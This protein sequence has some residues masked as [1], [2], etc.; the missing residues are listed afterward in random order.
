MKKLIAIAIIA[1][2]AMTASAQMMTSRTLLKRTNPA[3]W[4]VHAGMSINSLTGLDDDDKDNGYSLGSKA[5]FEVDFGFNKA[6]GRSGAYWG[7]ELGIGQRGGKVKYY[8]RYDDEEYESSISSWAV[9]YTPI[10]F[11]YK[12][13]FTDKIKADIHLGGFVSYDFSQKAKD[14]DGDEYDPFNNNLDAGIICGLGVWYSKFNLDFSY[15]R[16]FIE[17]LNSDINSSAFIIRVGYAF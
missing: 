5:G 3:T 9:K 2:S 10:N 12:Y 8:N 4:Y 13:S 11:G 14:E 6:I 7:M 17:Y 1:V 16:G 15:Q